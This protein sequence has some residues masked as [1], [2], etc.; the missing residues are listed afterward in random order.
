MKTAASGRKSPGRN[1]TK[2]NTMIR[3]NEQEYLSTEDYTIAL[4]QY[5]DYLLDLKLA[6]PQAPQ[7]IVWT[8]DTPEDLVC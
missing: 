2:L 6:L 8:P 4:N 7:E 3:P 5:I 1:G